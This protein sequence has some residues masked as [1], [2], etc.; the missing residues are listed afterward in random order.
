[1]SKLEVCRLFDHLPAEQLEVLEARAVVRV[2]AEDEVVFQEGDA[3]DGLYVVL[4]GQLQ[5]SCL[6]GATDRRVLS[7]FG[8]GD[9]VGEMAVLDEGARSA[10][11]TAVVA[12][13]LAFLPRQAV[14]EALE[15]TPVFAANLA[16]LV[17][18]RMR[19]FNQV[20]TEEVLQ[21]E[22]LVL[23]G[24]FARSIVHDFKN[25]LNVIGISADMAVME[26]ATPEVR[27]MA[28]GRIRRQVDR[29]SNMISELLEFTRGGGAQMV[30][31]R[32]D[33]GQFV[34]SILEEVSQEMESRRVKLVQEGEVPRV[35][36]QMN[37][38]RLAHVFHNL[39]NN[40]CDAMPDGGTWTCR[41]FY[42]DGRVVSEFQDTG[43]GIAPEMEGRLFE[44][45]ATYGKTSGTGL[46]LSI[47][48][49]I[50]ED[51]GGVIEAENAQGGGALF[52]F[53][54]PA[55]GQS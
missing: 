13:R 35:L 50:V 27:Q 19:E 11:V 29:M 24:R 46:G 4:G 2:Y 23:V 54:L 36:V 40:A 37:P 41:F 6:I 18:G 30:L 22:R 15:G 5:A 31:A 12:S 49:R 21:A 17:V 47:C 44:A 3:G 28:R 45:F 39:A 48:R 9:F 25:P 34:A 8:E 7:H 26:Q 32:L 16:R 1:M 43:C 10:T 20:Y 33:F 52:R 53:K 14:V 55:D 51:H 38:K 42:E